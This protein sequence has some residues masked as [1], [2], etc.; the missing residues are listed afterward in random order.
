M[1]AGGGKGFKA[2]DSRGS[3]GGAGKTSVN[4]LKFSADLALMR[5]VLKFMALLN[6]VLAAMPTPRKN[7]PMSRTNTL[8][9][10]R[11]QRRV[12]R[13]HD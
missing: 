6:W 4:S 11:V 5:V 12:L 2:L 8:M 13:A 9:V 3:D 7:S 10:T 1:S